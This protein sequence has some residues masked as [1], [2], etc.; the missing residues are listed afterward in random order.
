MYCSHFFLLSFFIL[1]AIQQ[2]TKIRKKQTKTTPPTPDPIAKYIVFP[3]KIPPTDTE[4]LTEHT[5]SER[6]S[7]LT[8]Q[9]LSVVS[10]IPPT[11]IFL[12]F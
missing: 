12:V 8:L 11:T 9:N 4:G 1:Q 10:S 3:G 7:I 5:G 6:D 2:H